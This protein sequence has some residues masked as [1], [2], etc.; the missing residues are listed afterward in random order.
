VN[1]GLRGARE[2]VEGNT[3]VWWARSSWRSPVPPKW[4]SGFLERKVLI[5]ESRVVRVPTVG[6]F[7]E[8]IISDLWLYKY[9]DTR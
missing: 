4:G 7:E 5:S 2:G 3:L 1:G 6:R 8:E 9:H